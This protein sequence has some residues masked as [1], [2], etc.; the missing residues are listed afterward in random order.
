M[1]YNKI[2]IFILV[3]GE[4]VAGIFILRTQPIINETTWMPADTISDSSEYDV[5]YVAGG[6]FWCVESDFEKLEGVVS[7]VS[8]F[9]GGS[10]VHPAYK[11]VSSGITGHRETVAVYYDSSRVSYAELVLHLLKH[12]DPTDPDGSFYD[13]G[14]QYTSAV[15]YGTDEEKEIAEA[16]IA[17]VDAKHIF[18]TPIATVV[19]PASAF[20]EAEEYHQDYY[21]KNPI[22]YGYY[23]SGSGRDDFVKSVWGDV[24]YTL[25]EGL[26]RKK[27]VAVYPWKTFTKPSDTELKARL[28]DSAYRV[29]QED[30]TERP[31]D[32]EFFDSK[33]VGIY[34]DIIS[35]EPLFSST[36]KYD[37]GT[38]WPSFW[39]PITEETIVHKKDYILG[40]PRTEVRSYYGDSHLGHVF[41]DGP[42][43]LPDGTPASGLRYCINSAA[44]RFVAKEDMQA[45]GYGDYRYLFE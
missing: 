6:C 7:G 45:E 38:G 42:D 17:D 10:V 15:Y 5:V 25:P 8:G 41:E 30:A 24:L 26:V 44:L 43:V 27:E 12:S 40:F 35:G 34:V 32:N 18:D 14:Y 31:F 4:L 2:I 16:V 11:E 3:L 33:E 29:T 23:R 28:S 19:E 13:R 21:K 9:M 22:R 20:Y 36:H 1:S 37:S 39:R